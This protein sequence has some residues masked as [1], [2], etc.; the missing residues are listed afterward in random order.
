MDLPLLDG[1]LDGV[2][3]GVQDVL[4]D[5]LE[6]AGTQLK[7]VGERVGQLGPLELALLVAQAGVYAGRDVLED[8]S[9]HQLLPVGSMLRPK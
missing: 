5:Q 1:H 2:V 6:R 4:G 9:V 7:L 8:V 3:V